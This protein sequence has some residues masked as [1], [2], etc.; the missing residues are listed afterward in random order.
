MVINQKR[1]KLPYNGPS[2][3]DG[4]PGGKSPEDAS[5]MIG[6]AGKLLL[7]YSSIW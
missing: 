2:D 1:T 4:G 6:L 7:E 5:N 3:R